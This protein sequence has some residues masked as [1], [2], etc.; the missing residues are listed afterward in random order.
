MLKS[1]SSHQML[2]AERLSRY[3]CLSLDDEIFPP[4]VLQDHACCNVHI[5]IEADFEGRHRDV[6]QRFVD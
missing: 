4:C 2:A 3:H 6:L 5:G 1:L